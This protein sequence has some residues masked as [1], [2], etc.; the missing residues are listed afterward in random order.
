M[1]YSSNCI[2]D[3]TLKIIFFLVLSVYLHILW[4]HFFK[5]SWVMCHGVNALH[6]LYS[7]VGGQVG[8]FQ[9]LAMEIEQKWPLLRKYLCG[10]KKHS[11]NICPK[12]AILH[13]KVDE[14]SSSWGTNTPIFW[15]A[16]QGCPPTSLPHPHQQELSF[17][18]MLSIFKKYYCW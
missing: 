11:L 9:F 17:S 1:P 15:V 13:H 18:R 7:S 4:C 2:W 3:T 16:V 5:N 14:F 6:F 8:C 12:V 10:I